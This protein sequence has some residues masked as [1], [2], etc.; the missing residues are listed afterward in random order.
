MRGETNVKYLNENRVTIWDEWADKDGELGP[1]YGYQWRHWGGSQGKGIDQISALV[2]GLKSNPHSRRHIVN[3]WN[4]SDVEK[5]ALPPCHVL[6]QFYVHNDDR[7]SC[8]LYQRSAD[9]FLGVPFNIASYALLTLMIAQATGLKPGNFVHTFGDAHLYLNHVEQAKLQ[10]TRTP[11]ALPQMKILN[12]HP[13]IFDFRF[14]DFKL[15][16]Y[17]PHPSIKGGN[18]RMKLSLIVAM[19]DDGVIGK[20]NKLPWHISE[21]LKRFKRI[22][23]ANP[24]IMGR[25][26]FES[27]GKALPGRHNIVVTRNLEFAASGVSV[28]HSLDA[29]IGLASQ[30]GEEENFIIGGAEIFKMALPITGQTL[31]N[32]DSPLL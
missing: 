27:I 13:S 9:I 10:L 7:L 17:E 1:V 29:A 15:E 31:P 19:T 30:D 6:F 12:A 2:E 11:R 32:A 4:V 24:I 18:I 3:A 8:Q 21:D 28:C 23:M 5:M 16:N 20:G 22:T 26:T 14:E 25:K